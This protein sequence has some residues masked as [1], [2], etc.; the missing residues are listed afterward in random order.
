MIQ[1]R[2]KEELESEKQEIQSLLN[3]KELFR[4]FKYKILEESKQLN[5]LTLA[6]GIETSKLD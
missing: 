4:E 5:Q 3:K 2:K 1:E 6:Y